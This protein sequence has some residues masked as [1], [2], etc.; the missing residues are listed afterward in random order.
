MD[1]FVPEPSSFKIISLRLSNA[2]ITSGLQ[3]KIEQGM[4]RDKPPVHSA[5]S[6]HENLETRI[7]FS[8]FKKPRREM[9]I[10]NACTAFS[11]Q[12][13]LIVLTHDRIKRFDPR[14]F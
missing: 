2:M 4:D 11:H 8:L 9:R 13:I 1:E 14:P 5:Q 10:H 7:N 3:D 12:S 6:F